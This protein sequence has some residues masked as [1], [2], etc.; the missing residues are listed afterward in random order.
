M[1]MS[2]YN[3]T[4]SIDGAPQDQPFSFQPGVGL[5]EGWT[6]GVLKMNEGERSWLSVPSA[7][8]YGERAMGSPGGAGRDTTNR[9]FRVV[10][11]GVGF[12][13]LERT[14]NKPDASETY[15]AYTEHYIVYVSVAITDVSA[16]GQK[17]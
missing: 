13:K 12:L 17:S 1:P 9:I 6:E 3:P 11:A 8:G 2:S 4:I 7:K 16:I 5:I 15:H 14:C 10:A